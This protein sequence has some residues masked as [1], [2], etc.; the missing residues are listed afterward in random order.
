MQPKITK[1]ALMLAC[2]TVTPAYASLIQ[3]KP[4]IPSSI[5]QFQ[6]NP[7]TLAEFARNN[8]VIYAHP[9]QSISLPTMKYGQKVS[10]KYYSAA[11][12]VPASSKNV[13]RLLQNYSNYAGLFPTL[14]HAKILEQR[15]AIARVK[16]SVHIPT[17]IPVL[18]FRESVIM[19]HQIEGNSITS[20][21][22]DAPV[23]YGTGKL[24]WFEL[25]PNQ[26]L[27]T[28]TQWG[29]LNH[30][31]G[32][33]LSKILS[34]LPDAK[35]GIP[36]GTNGFLLEALQRRFKTSVAL[37][38]NTSL[39]N[40]NLTQTQIQKVVQISQSSQEPVSFIL[41]A[42]KTPYAHGDEI[43]RFSTSY[44]YYAQSPAQLQSWL[45]A[46]A[47][48][49]LFP[50]QV[51][52]LKIK[53]I[54]QKQLDADYKISV[55]LGVIHIPFDFKMRFDFPNALQNQFHATGG[56]LKL[57]RGAMTLSPL[58]QG[59]LLNVTS[60]LKIDDEAPFLLRA[61]RNFPY[62]DMLPAIGG[63][64]VFTLKI[65]QMNK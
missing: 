50:R 54:N 46:P 20:L 33:L 63:N 3:W 30:T 58:K 31:K 56:D 51:K 4:Q 59:S 11:V 2:C 29:D 23:P 17:P 53:Q 25:A 55:G 7:Q 64:T 35:L 45:T 36:A 43:M 19:Q 24:E 62:H 41:P 28:V 34:A 1:M 44:Q 49:Q 15:G 10:G 60:A 9:T 27:I 47:F 16:Y 8:I 37:P 18:N 21:V 32:F 52:D 61:M 5:S 13:A 39:P 26:T 6:S 42:Q 14:K 65:Q 22:L 38:L 48:Q 12:V 40:A 57:V